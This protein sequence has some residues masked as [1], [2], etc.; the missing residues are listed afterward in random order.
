MWLMRVLLSRMK[1][2]YSASSEIV[3]VH[4]MRGRPYPYG[5]RASDGVHGVGKM[6]MMYCL[7]VCDCIRV[8]GKRTCALVVMG[9]MIRG[10]DL[11]MNKS[12][13][14]VKVSALAS[15]QR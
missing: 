4:I 13:A 2:V 3:E 9:M 14:C 7:L 5:D 12:L 6:V 10:T 11:E 8:R 15:W 1:L